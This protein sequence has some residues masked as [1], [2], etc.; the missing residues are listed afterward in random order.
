MKLINKLTLI[1]LAIVVSIDLKLCAEESVSSAYFE[2]VE[3]R[4]IKAKAILESV[5]KHISE[6]SPDFQKLKNL[7]YSDSR[8]V[9]TANFSYESWLSLVDKQCYNLLEKMS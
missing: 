1:G 9:F 8:N 2:M 6:N 4:V 5:P 3:E 7:I